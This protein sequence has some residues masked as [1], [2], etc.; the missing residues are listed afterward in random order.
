MSITKLRVVRAQKGFKSSRALAAKSGVDE[1]RY[2]ATEA[3]RRSRYLTPEEVRRVSEVLGVVPEKLFDEKG[4][5][6]ELEDVAV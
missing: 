4:A 5:A 3:K 2:V 6:L 1:V